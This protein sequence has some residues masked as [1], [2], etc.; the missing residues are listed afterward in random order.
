MEERGSNADYLIANII[1]SSTG[2]NGGE[3]SGYLGSMQ[4]F[5]VQVPDST[6]ANVS[7]NEEMRTI[8]NNGD[9]NY[10]RTFNDSKI[11]ITI[12][13]EEQNESTTLIGFVEEATEGIDRLYDATKFFGQQ[14]L[15]IYSIIENK[16]FAIQGIPWKESLTLPIGIQKQ[17]AGVLYVALE[18][19]ESLPLNQNVLLH[20]RFTDEY[21]NLE[22]PIQIQATEGKSEDRFEIVLQTESLL[23]VQSPKLK[24][25]TGATKIELSVDSGRPISEVMLIDMMGRVLLNQEFRSNHVSIH[26]PKQ[27]GVYILKTTDQSGFIHSVKVL[28]D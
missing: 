16:P 11:W 24:V 17:N 9:A 26:R 7:F 10:F 22:T 25:V 6:T 1:G 15:N 19:E 18:G 8:G 4:G 20:D 13:D 5:F 21:W 2:P 23:S 28:I 27:R 3:F 12:S 14:D